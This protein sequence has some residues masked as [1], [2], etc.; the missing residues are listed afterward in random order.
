MWHLITNGHCAPQFLF[1]YD[2]G[3]EIDSTLGLY[4]P[5]LIRLH[6]EN[7]MKTTQTSS[8][9]LKREYTV[10]MT[11]AD[12]EERL[13]TELNNIKDKIRVNGF[14]PGKVPTAHV[15]KLYGRSV[16]ADVVQ[17]A[18][19]EAN[20]QIVNDN[21]LKLAFEPQINFPEDKEH[22]E[23]VMDAKADLSYTVAL[24]ILPTF[25]IKDVK[26]LS[27][28]KEVAAPSDKDLKEAL[29]T[30]AKQNTTFAPK[31]EKAKAED[32]DRLK[33][34][35]LGKIDDVA[36]E[37]GAAEGIDLVLGSNTFIPGFEEQLL[38]AKK[39]EDRDVKVSFPVNYGAQHLAGKEAHFTVKVK[40]HLKTAFKRILTKKHAS[41]SRSR[42]SMNLIHSMILISPPL[43]L[44][45]S[46]MGSGLA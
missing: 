33:I 42:S 28:T 4:A 17:N 2:S 31:A 14:R 19:N 27:L 22:I 13:V 45:K 29:E 8:V 34:N 6:E 23:A 20:R 15:R 21:N 24:E 36:F 5:N 18:V 41:N 39:G 11:A 7:T 26:G 25:E 9:G 10:V 37:G 16:M 12:L 35:F 32:G 3:L 40:R 1:I 30:L 38:G 46:L 43:L 44:S